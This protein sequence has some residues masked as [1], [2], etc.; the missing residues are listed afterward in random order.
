MVTDFCGVYSWGPLSCSAICP[1]DARLC[2]TPMELR[3]PPPRRPRHA[4]QTAHLP[5]VGVIWLVAPA[6]RPRLAPS[7]DDF[8]PALLSFELA[9]RASRAGERR[10]AAER[11]VEAEPRCG[12]AP[13][14]NR[15]FQSSQA[16]RRSTVQYFQVSCSAVKSSNSVVLWWRP[17]IT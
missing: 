9:F 11:R 12:K 3:T 16:N 4:Q 13:S 2:L 15:T 17:L 6:S 10:L 7:Q 5:V 8:T 14:R 1:H